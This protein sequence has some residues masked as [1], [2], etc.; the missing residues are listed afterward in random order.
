[1]SP[2]VAPGRR[3]LTTTERALLDAFLARDFPGV[4]E[5]RGQSPAATASPGCECGCGTVDLH[6]PDGFPASVAETPVPVETTV[7]DRD[8]DAIGGLLLF[9]ADGRLDRL[10][11]YSFDDPL[12]LPP[13]AQV[14]WSGA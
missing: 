6:V 8:G 13:I 12:P 11:V 3:P 10:E 2:E 14:R 9:V 4:A 5:L 1:M 7:V